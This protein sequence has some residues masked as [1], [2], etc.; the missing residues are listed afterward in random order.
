MKPTFLRVGIAKS[1][2]K[3]PG[4]VRPPTEPTQSTLPGLVECNTSTGGTSHDWDLPAGASGDLGIAYILVADGETLTTPTGWTVLGSQFDGGSAT[5]Y[6]LYRIY[7][8]TE[9]TPITYTTSGS[10][11]SIA[12]TWLLF[13]N[14]ADLTNGLPEASM[15]FTAANGTP[16]PPSITPTGGAGTYWVFAG[17]SVNT[18]GWSVGDAPT[19]YTYF[20]NCATSAPPNESAVTWALVDIVTSE[21]P[22]DFGNAVS[23]TRRTIQYTIAVPLTPDPVG[24]LAS[25]DHTHN[26]NDADDVGTGATTKGDLLVHDGTDYE[27]LPL[28][29]STH[30][31]TVDNAEALGV[32]WAAGGGGGGTGASHSIIPG[33]GE[34][35]LAASLTDSQLYRQVQNVQTQTPVTAAYNGELVGLSVASSEARTAGTATFEVF[36]N[37]TGTGLTTVLDATDTQ[38]AFAVQVAG[39]DSFSAGDRLDVR[40]T[41]DGSW[42]PT[43]A[44]VEVTIFVT[45][46]AAI[47]TVP[48]WIAYLNGRQPDE[49]GNTDDDFFTDATKTGF[50]ETTVTGTATWTEI[51]DRMSVKALSGATGDAA[52]ALKSLTAS[53]PPVTVETAFITDKV[54]SDFELVGVCFTDGTA[55]TSNVVW[56]AELSRAS[57]GN[58][59][60][61]ATGTLT[62]ISATT[63]VTFANTS[64]Q[65]R[66]LMHIRLVETAANTWA[67]NYSPNGID[68]HDMGLAPF[69]FTMTPTHYGLFIASYNSTTQPL[70]ASWEY[71]RMH[72]SDLDV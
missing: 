5:G 21:D 1:T 49:T 66:G 14:G 37:G 36:I 42:T 24:P 72:E 27:R 17:A 3:A 20:D 45:S 60:Q 55:S 8:G 2:T 28:G 67:A 44:D 34:D 62:N 7:D 12:Q 61:V 40:V 4:T 13:A 15:S 69:S 16:N 59:I 56:I 53:R 48:E 23:V 35:N 29:S 26:V 32:K 38:Y 39:S 51:R 19:G 70:I 33:F 71:L 65:Y 43:T 10:A 63:R 57:G 11:V 47:G 68:W 22:S 50:T 41:T 58:N 31:L 52:V 18:T 46:D 64:G 9:T 6:I 54:G 30:V 25:G